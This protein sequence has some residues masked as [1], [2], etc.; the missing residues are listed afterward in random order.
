MIAELIIG[1]LLIILGMYLLKHK[2]GCSDEEV[3]IMFFGVFAL[4]VLEQLAKI[5]SK[6]IMST[7]TV[8]IV[9]AHIISMLISAFFAYMIFRKTGI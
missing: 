9:I 3:N 8:E 1:V 6:I 4:Q 5:I 2:L 7:A